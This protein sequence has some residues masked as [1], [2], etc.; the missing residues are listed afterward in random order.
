MK[1]SPFYLGLVGCVALAWG[2]LGVVRADTDST[3]YMKAWK[4]VGGNWLGPPTSANNCNTRDCPEGMGGAGACQLRDKG[5]S[6]RYPGYNYAICGCAQSSSQRCELAYY[7]G[8]DPGDFFYACPP[9][10]ACADVPLTPDCTMD[11][12]GTGPFSCS[13]H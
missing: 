8:T 2:L 7:Y 10:P 9:N 13:C 11:G 3:C 12:S 5:A 4:N 6:T 1:L